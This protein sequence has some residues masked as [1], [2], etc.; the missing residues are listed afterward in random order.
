MSRVCAAIAASLIGATLVAQA[1]DA[2]PGRIVH[3]QEKRKTLIARAKVWLPTDI[4]SQNLLIGPQGR[5]AFAPGEIVTCDYQPRKFTGTSPKFWCRLGE[6]K[7]FKVKYGSG[8]GEV[9]G[10]VVGS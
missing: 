10:E 5:G 9:Y 3:A 4:P 7:A 6:G 1:E 8:N 2:E